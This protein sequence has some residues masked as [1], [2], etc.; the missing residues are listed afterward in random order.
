MEPQWPFPIPMCL[1]TIFADM[2]TTPL[3]CSGLLLS[4]LLNPLAPVAAADSNIYNRNWAQ[5]RGP[6]AN[7]LALQGNPPL[8]W[9]EEKNIK[10]KV[11]IPGRGHATPIIWEDKVFVLTAVPTENPASAAIEEDIGPLQFVQQGPGRPRGGPGR[12]GGRGGLPAVEHAFTVLC[13]DRETGQVLWERIARRETPQGIQ[14]A[15]SHSSGSPV[16]DGR[17]VYVYFGSHGLYCYDMEGNL[18]WE[19]DLGKMNVTFGE[20][21]SPVLAGD[22]LIVLQDHNGPSSIA[23]LDKKTGREIWRTARDEGSGWTTPYIL[24]HGGEKQVVVSGSNAVRSY[25][26]ETGKLIWQCSG[27]GSNPVAMVVADEERVYAMSGHRAPAALAIRLGR[28][29]DLTDTDAVVWT[30]N[31][32]T[33]YVSSPLLW[34]GLLFFFQG[35]RDRITC[36]DAATGKP[37]IDQQPLEG[38]FGIYAS[39][40]GVNNRIYVPGQNGMTAV[41]E[42]SKELTILAQN[43]LEDGFDASPA[44]AGD[45]LFLRGREYLYC[46]AAQ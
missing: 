6:S 40:V 13:L 20:G 16:T 43:Q 32:G 9:S 30:I 25:E 45:E 5:W 38:M 23:A 36:L 10:W 39:P 34:D 3:L 1:I 28:S 18:V 33:P 14:P 44:L 37:H 8:E 15:N 21:T 7:G 24:E 22:K 19:K 26:L 29:G 27:L 31:S 2:R 4:F 35:T 46:I 12:P 11:K 17:H 41:L 42:K